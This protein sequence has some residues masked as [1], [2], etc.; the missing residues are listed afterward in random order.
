MEWRV[1]KD[2]KY[3]EVN[4]LGEIRSLD[5]TSI[6]VLDNGKIK[7]TVHYGKILKQK[8]NKKGYMEVTIVYDEGVGKKTR[9]VH[10][11]ILSAFC[12]NENEFELQVN[13]K[14]GIKNDNRLENLEW[15]TPKENT[16][17]AYKI[18]LAKHKEQNGELNSQAKLCENDVIQIINLLKEGVLT[19]KSIGEKFGVSRGCIGL[20]KNNKTWRHIPRN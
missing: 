16:H 5:K 14:N 3:Y 6:K 7:K 1:V 11:L 10:R 19:H 8:T 9:L 12:P 4:E 20:I 15:V 13:H 2:A 17:H 18:G